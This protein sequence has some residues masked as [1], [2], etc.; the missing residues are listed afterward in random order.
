LS[1][2]VHRISYN[3][4]QYHIPGQQY[5]WWGA[6]CRLE[7]RKKIFEV[8]T[9]LF[10]FQKI[11]CA[12][13]FQKY[14]P[15]CTRW[16]ICRIFSSRRLLTARTDR[17]ETP[18]RSQ[19]KQRQKQALLKF[20]GFIFILQLFD[21]KISCCKVHC[22]HHSHDWDSF[23][24]LTINSIFERNAYSVKHSS[25]HILLITMTFLLSIPI[26]LFGQN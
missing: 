9:V 2:I 8:S 10:T 25:F 4:M 22:P 7:K 3:I 6:E 5:H 21:L 1:S 13:T 17:K 19:K 15:F 23:C 14:L 20:L 24:V 26:Q 11:L 16:F 12:I 18:K